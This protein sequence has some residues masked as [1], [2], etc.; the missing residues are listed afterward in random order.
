MKLRLTHTIFTIMI[1]F[2]LGSLLFPLPARGA[3]KP[4]SDSSKSSDSFK[5]FSEVT[6]DTEK[7]QGLFTLYQGKEG[8]LYLEIQPEQLDTNFQL[9]LSL[10][11]GM[12]DAGILTGSPLDDYLFQFRRVNDEIQFIRENPYFRANSNTPLARAVKMDFTD[13]ILGNFKILSIHPEK[14]S[15]LIDI[16]ELVMSDLPDLSRAL[17]QAVKGNYA[18]DPSKSSIDEVLAFPENVEIDVKAN[19]ATNAPPKEA[20]FLDSL[21]DWRSIPLGIHFSFSMLPTGH[22]QPRLA[23]DRIGYFVSAVKDFSS[24]NPDTSIVEYVNRWDMAKKPVLFWIENTVPLEYR[25]PIKE[26]VLEWNKAFSKIGIPN[27][28]D[29]KVQPE[30]ANWNSLDIRYNVIHWISSSKGSFAGLGPSHVNPLTGEI[31]NASVLL[32]E[33]AVKRIKYIYRYEIDEDH[34]GEAFSGFAKNRCLFGPLKAQEA[35][36]A[37]LRLALNSD[38][39]EQF[40]VPQDFV[41]AYIK[42]V[43][44]HE[45]GHCLGLRHNFHGST[46]LS[47]KN[48]GN[49][50]ITKKT[51]LSSSIMDYTAINIASRGTKQGEYFSSTIGPYD[52]WA[53]E[54]GYVPTEV[55]SPVD[56]EHELRKITDQSA[57]PAY[58]YETDEDT[59]GPYNVDPLSAIFDLSNDPLAF[60]SRRYGL[61]HELWDEMTVKL[62]LRGESYNQTRRAFDLVMGGFTTISQIPIRFVGGEYFS[63]SHAGDRGAKLPLRPVERREQERALDVLDQNLFADNAFH[64]SPE[65]LNKLAGDRKSNHFTEIHAYLTPIDYPMREKVSSIQAAILDELFRPVLLNRLLDNERRVSGGKGTFTLPDLFDWTT[66]HFW[67]EL[68]QETNISDLR[69]TLQREYLN[70][71]IELVLQPRPQ[72]FA[73][74]ELDMP[75]QPIATVPEDATSLA[76]HHLEIIRD[77]IRRVLNTAAY[78]PNELTRTHLLASLR[79][80]DRALQAKLHQSI[81][82]RALPQ[83]EE[84]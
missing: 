62:P 61:Y 44:M 69:R 17:N 80:I 22:Y 46:L 24:E 10:S 25:E 32:D 4:P 56:E 76:L 64:F 33:D 67:K 21:P 39:P 45:I 3:E 2:T 70:R 12:G 26:A 15:I 28:V 50:S 6:K 7:I 84:E 73:I 68:D 18:F 38:H 5:P 23:D 55:S 31:Y 58:A 13:A 66:T 41:D 47:L 53:I 36:G 14:K 16:G 57:T 51:G 59:Y 1:L 48:L 63:R 9:T 83:S 65:L 54:Y 60:A 43:V 11:H 20:P 34:L 81:R 40:M 77:K 35:A 75:P 74:S 19:F 52:Y 72:I 8:K 79:L 37:S 78:H 42:E 27:E 71:L 82:E 30:N 49:P 29:V